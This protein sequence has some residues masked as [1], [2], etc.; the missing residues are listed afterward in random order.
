M[1]GKLTNVDKVKKEIEV[2]GY[3]KQNFLNT[4]RLMHITGVAAQ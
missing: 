3:I 2:T 4:K 1:L